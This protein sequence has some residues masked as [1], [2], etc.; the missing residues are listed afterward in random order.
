R[1]RLAIID[2]VF[3]VTEVLVHVDPEDDQNHPMPIDY[4]NRQEMLDAMSKLLDT[5]EGLLAIADLVLH[6][7][8]D[9]MVADLVLT[10][11]PQRNLD[12]LRLASLRL[13]NKIIKTQNR[14]TNV[15]LKT[16]LHGCDR[17][18]A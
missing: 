15:R 2:G 1:M 7:T 5:E 3:E 17:G 8:R 12:D 4:P 11:D 13:C 18:W 14:V 6:Y 10:V 9:G 16:V